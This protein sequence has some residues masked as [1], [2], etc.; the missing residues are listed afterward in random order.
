MKELLKAW[1]E[2]EQRLLER[3]QRAVERLHSAHLALADHQPSPAN[4]AVT[5]TLVME[6]SAAGAELDVVRRDVL[7]VRSDLSSGKRERD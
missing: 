5:A 4:Q 6:A 3:W 2:E 1:R 7:R